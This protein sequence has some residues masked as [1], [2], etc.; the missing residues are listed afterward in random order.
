M[1]VT[2]RD[3]RPLSAHRFRIRSSRCC[4]REG[5][6][7]AHFPSLVWTS[8]RF[9]L[10]QNNAFASSR[11]CETWLLEQPLN[12][13]IQV[14]AIVQFPDFIITGSRDNSLKLWSSIGDLVKT[15]SMAHADWILSMKTIPGRD[16]F[17]SIARDGSL[18]VSRVTTNSSCWYKS[19]LNAKYVFFNWTPLE[20][21]VSFVFEYL[22]K[23]LE[24]RLTMRF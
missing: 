8:S 12:L 24:K 16:A 9:H 10:A 5:Q 21:I 3:N 6:F 11:Y 4:R 15:F 17:V 13:S 23:T 18:A 22:R 14:T 1:R 20:Q 7:H 19:K 2:F